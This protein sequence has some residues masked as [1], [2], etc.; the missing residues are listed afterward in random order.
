MA[1]LPQC[2]SALVQLRSTRNQVAPAPLHHTYPRG[3]AVADPGGGQPS[4]VSWACRA[5]ARSPGGLRS[6]RESPGP[7]VRFPRLAG[8]FECH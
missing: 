6:S 1:P 2:V 8:R 3:P 4:R 5:V 7:L